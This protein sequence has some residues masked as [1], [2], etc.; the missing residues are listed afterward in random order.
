MIFKEIKLFVCELLDEIYTDNK[1][2][3]ETELP[4]K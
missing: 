1:C 3:E 2:G 4:K